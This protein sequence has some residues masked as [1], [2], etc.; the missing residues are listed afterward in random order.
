MLARKRTSNGSPTL[1]PDPIAVSRQA[2]AS[3]RAK[4]QRGATSC[5]ASQIKSVESRPA[6][7]SPTTGIKP[8]MH[9]N[10]QQSLERLKM[11][12]TLMDGAFVIPGT[13]IRFGLP[14][15]RW[16]RTPELVNE[17]CAVTKDSLRQAARV[18]NH[19]NF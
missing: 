2:F 18:G 4:S 8:M 10:T 5:F 6:I 16:H 14:N 19:L 11:L 13:T 9:Q 15:R 3:I 7:M 1:G 17:K 12:A